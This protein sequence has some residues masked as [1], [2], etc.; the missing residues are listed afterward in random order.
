MRAL[1]VLSLVAALGGALSCQGY[2]TTAPYG[3]G[4][5]GGIGGGSGGGASVQVGDN[6]FTPVAVTVNVGD[7]ITFTWVGANAHNV[8]FSNGPA[9]TTQIVGTFQT[10][11][12]TAGTYSYFCTIHQGTGMAGTVIVH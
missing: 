6:Q 11:F 5:G 8:T 12:A 10:S 3:G 2:G 7:P 9:S 4:G 1:R